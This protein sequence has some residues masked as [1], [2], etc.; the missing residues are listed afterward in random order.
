MGRDKTII[1]QWRI[2]GKLNVEIAK[3]PQVYATRSF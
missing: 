2:I 3:S 1:V